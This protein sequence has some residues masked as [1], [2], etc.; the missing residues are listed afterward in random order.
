[1]PEISLLTTVLPA[2]LGF[3]VAIIA[4]WLLERL[5][6]IIGGILAT[7]PHL[8]VVGTAF[9]LANSNTPHDALIGVYSSI[10]SVLLDIIYLHAW[11]YIPKY[12]PNINVCSIVFWS[13]VI[14]FICAFICY[15]IIST[16][17]VSATILAYQL[18][19]II[20]TIIL[21]IIGIIGNIKYYNAPK[22]NNRV[23]LGI[24]LIRGF[25][26]GIVTLVVSLSAELNYPIIAGLFNSFPIL[27]TVSMA[28][29][30]IT[31]GKAVSLG[32]LSPMILGVTCVNVFAISVA[33]F[34]QYIF[35]TKNQ[36][37]HNMGIILFGSWIAAIVI[38]SIPTFLL[39]R[40]LRQK[41]TRSILR[42]AALPTT[43][44]SNSKAAINNVPKHDYGTIQIDDSCQSPEAERKAV[45]FVM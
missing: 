11:K 40:L 28:S 30:W 23:S 10:F 13:F 6:G 7:T 35:K 17:L 44:S 9:I 20:M 16:L 25:A 39:I 38:I 15:L 2:V 26:C 22:G 33:T 42:Y 29:L 3:S 21:I 45:K 43:P 18:L 27:F 5:G 32:A 24:H 37:V 34:V 14:W 36:Y 4:T 12:F 31:Q 19:T 1:M 41:K 8:F